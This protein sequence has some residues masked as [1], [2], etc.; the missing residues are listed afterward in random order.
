MPSDIPRS[1]N[2]VARRNTAT[3]TARNNFNLTRTGTML[4]LKLMASIIGTVPT[5]NA[6]M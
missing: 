4:P 1:I 3:G 2:R 6:A 5:P